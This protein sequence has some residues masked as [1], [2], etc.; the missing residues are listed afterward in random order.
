MIIENREKLKEIA[1]KLRKEGKKIVFTNGCFDILHYGHAE[2]LKK[3]KMLG[4]VLIV[5]INTDD[6]V[7]RIKG[8]E[9]PINKLEHR[10]KVLD[11]IRYV[12]YVVPF[13]E[14]TPENLIRIIKPDVHVKG[15][16]YKNKPIPERKIV[17]SYGGKVVFVDLVEGISTTK[18]IEKIRKLRIS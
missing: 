14:N 18:I 3:A 4:D 11:A 16:D 5:G 8:K 1:E 12:D 6:S 10:M 15:S 13:N 17:E 2:C 7:R 9:R